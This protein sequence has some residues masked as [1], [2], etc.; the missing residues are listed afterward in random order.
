SAGS[1]FFIS[2]DGLVV[3]NN[4]VIDGATEV[5]VALSDGREL[6]A[7]VLG[8]DASTDLAVLKVRTPGGKRA[9]YPFVRFEDRVAPRVGDWVIAIG[10]PFGL[11]GSATAGVVSGSGRTIGDGN[12]AFLQ[13]D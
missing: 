8:R 5:S 4:H 13:I 6:Q 1:G 7:D 11:G 9:A 10:N 3:T 2:A 12:V